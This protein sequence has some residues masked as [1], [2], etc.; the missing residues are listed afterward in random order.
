MILV[1]YKYLKIAHSVDNHNFSIYN[2]NERIVYNT[3]KHKTLKY[4]EQCEKIYR[5]KGVE[6]FEALKLFLKDSFNI[7]LILNK[8]V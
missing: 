8:G 5:L 2:G 6:H 7:E 3:Y 4:I 1:S